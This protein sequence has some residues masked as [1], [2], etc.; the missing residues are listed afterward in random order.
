MIW[1]KKGKIKKK[2]QKQVFPIGEPL[3]N[4]DL[5]ILVMEASEEGCDK[6]RLEYYSDLM[7]I[8]AESYYY[9]ILH[10]SLDYL[11]G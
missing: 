3:E 11:A 6:Y 9:G 8:T 10:C 4:K 2:K 1:D 7:E 5:A